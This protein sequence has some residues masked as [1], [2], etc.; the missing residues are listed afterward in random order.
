MEF[1]EF[2][3]KTVDEAI[4]KASIEYETSSE[5][6]E[7]QVISQGKAGFLGFGAKPAI[8]RAA[9]KE[10]E[11]VLPKETAESARK[12]A[13]AKKEEKK[14]VKP[15]AVKEEKKEQ[16]RENKKDNRKEIKKENPV[17]TQEK[18]KE[19][20]APEKLAEE[21]PR[22]E[23]KV[24][25]RTEEE[26][27]EIKEDAQKF[28]TGVFKAMELQ[29][30]IKM[31]YKNEE[32]NLNIDFKGDDMGILIGKRGQTLDSLQYLTSLVVNKGR[33]GYI[34]V[35]LDTEDYR[36]RR[37]ETLENLAR[38][39]AYKVRKTRRPVSLEPMNPY[40][41]R[42]IHSALQGNRFVET[43]SEGNEPYRH[44]VVKLKNR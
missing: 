40:E 21:K 36:N 20:P 25:L 31:E 19:T 44:V 34:R 30:E 29:V 8:I 43:Y 6:L 33:Q 38:S 11:E 41:R 22:E 16:K 28:L 9:K 18:P 35:K 32:G 24:T 13:P 42:I 14:S 3:A 15:Q 17:K 2:S 37:K 7:I 5:N 26:I 10:I 27:A 39:I 23:R 12:P 4:T 1:R